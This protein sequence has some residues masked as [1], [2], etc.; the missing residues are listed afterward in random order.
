MTG[1]TQPN[2]RNIPLPTKRDIRRRCGFGCVFCGIPLYEYDHMLGWANTHT[3]VSEEI[4]LLCDQH[5]REKTA[6]LLPIEVVR[7]ADANPFNLRSGSSKPY[8]LH[9]SGDSCEAILGSNTLTFQLALMEY[10]CFAFRL[11]KIICSSPS[12]FL[13]R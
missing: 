9:F 8:D 13:M 11:M 5:H 2:S 6:G 10:L 4:T 7:E 3:H 1:Q 12:G